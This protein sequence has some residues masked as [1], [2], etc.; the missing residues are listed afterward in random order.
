MVATTNGNTPVIFPSRTPQRQQ[1]HGDVHTQPSQLDDTK[2]SE[3]EKHDGN[4][5]TFGPDLP[6]LHKRFPST[7]D[8]V[9]KRQKQRRPLSSGSKAKSRSKAKRKNEIRSE[10]REAAMGEC[11]ESLRG[12]TVENCERR[13]RKKR[14]SRNGRRGSAWKTESRDS[15]S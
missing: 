6:L 1:L 11:M 13:W 9:M 7:T 3:E 2:P 10:I 12:L 5:G 14:G 15:K 8:R 4:D